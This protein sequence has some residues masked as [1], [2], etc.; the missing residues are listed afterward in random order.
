M[1]NVPPCKYSCSDIQVHYNEIDMV[2]NSFKRKKKKKKKKK[3]R[4]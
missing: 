1:Y 2:L 4:S 3:K